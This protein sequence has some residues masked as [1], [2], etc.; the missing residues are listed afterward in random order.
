MGKLRGGNS[1]HCRSKSKR[2]EKFQ[3]RIEVLCWNCSEKGYCKK[4]RS[5]PKK[6]KNS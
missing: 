4:D 2:W 1:R 5:K 3:G 6:N